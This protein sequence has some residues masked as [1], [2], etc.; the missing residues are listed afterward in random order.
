[1]P[2]EAGPS[3]AAVP[4]TDASAPAAEASTVAEASSS[5]GTNFRSLRVVKLVR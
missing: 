2:D 1:M 3:D 4:P 5:D